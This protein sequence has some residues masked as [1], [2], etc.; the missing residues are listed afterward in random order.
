VKQTAKLDKWATVIIVEDLRY[1][2]TVSGH[3][4]IEDGTLIYTSNVLRV[5]EEDGVKMVETRN[6]VYT[7]GE[8]SPDLAANMRT[9][10]M[11]GGAVN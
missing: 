10:G 8:F 1:A 4:K 9:L 3:P 2:G 6:T 7:L 11:N 5:Y